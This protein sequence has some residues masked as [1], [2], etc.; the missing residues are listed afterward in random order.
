V[1]KGKKLPP[2]VVNHWPEIFKDID[3][4]SVPVEYLDSVKITFED[5]KV[6]EIDTSRNPEGIPID[7]AL[8]SLMEE[9]EDVIVNVDFRLDTEK[10]KKNITQR[11]KFFMKKR[12]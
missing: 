1:P 2:D 5:G 3:I 11:T 7:E 4:E 12:K 9:Y 8:E 10:V 6:W